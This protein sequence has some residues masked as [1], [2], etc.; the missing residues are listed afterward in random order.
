MGSM[1]GMDSMGS[2][3]GACRTGI[4]DHTYL[5]ST[6]LQPTYRQTDIQTDTQADS[7]NPSV[8]ALLAGLP[9]SLLRHPLPKCAVCRPRPIDDSA[10]GR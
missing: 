7:P 5:V 3:V 1:G 4:S 2:A 10:I 6:Y 9:C 8:Y